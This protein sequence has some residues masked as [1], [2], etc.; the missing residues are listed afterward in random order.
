MNA[1]TSSITFPSQKRAD[2]EKSD[3]WAKECI[4][5]A[6]QMAMFNDEK[7]RQSQ[8]N[9]QIN[10]NL[11]NDILDEKD[12]HRICDPFNI[13]DFQAPAKVQNYPLCNPK[14][15]RLRGEELKRKF[16]WR[17]IVGNKEAISSKEMQKKEEIKQLLYSNLGEKYEENIAKQVLEKIERIRTTYQ[18]DREMTASKVLSYLWKTLD[19][20]TIFNDG[21]KDSL[22]AGEEI[23]CADIVA[24]EPIL[25]KV[26]PLNLYTIR[27]GE[28]AKIEDADIIIEDCYM[29][30]G[31]IIDAYY[32]YLK[33]ADV[34]RIE[35][36]DI[37]DTEAAGLL[38]Y[39]KDNFVLRNDMFGESGPMGM[40]DTNARGFDIF[41]SIY[42]SYGNIRVMRVVWKSRRKLQELTYIDDYGDEQKRVV[43]G[44][45]KANKT[46][47]EKTSE[48]W[49]NEFWE[50]TRIGGDL[51]IKIQPRPVQFR[52]MTNLSACQSGYIGSIY[53]TNL[54]RGKSLMD[55][56]KPYQYLY[57]TFMYRLEHAFAKYK[58]PIYELD[59]SKIPDEWTMDK[60]MY[61]AEVM[62]WAPID[63]FN[64]G[65]KGA[66]TGKLSG[67][68]NTTGK[69]LDA[70]IGN[71]IQQNINML[72]LIEV[73]M[74]KISGITPQREGDV[75]ASE[76]VGNVNQAITQSAFI[77]EPYF[78]LHDQTKL[79]VLNILLETAKYAWKESKKTVQFVLDDLSIQML[80]VDGE[81]F[82]EAEYDVHITNSGN[83]YEI[84]Q[85]IKQLA[86]AG[87]QNDKINFKQ[88]IDIYTSDSLSS[89]ARKIEAAEREKADG[90]Q[91]RF[92]QEMQV[93]QDQNKIAVENAER[94]MVLEEKKLELDK[95]KIDQDNATKI[96]IAEI[97]AYIGQES[98]DQ[99]GNGIPD[100][101]EIANLA[102][103]QQKANADQAAKQLDLNIKQAQLSQKMAIEKEKIEQIKT[104]NKSQEKINQE[105]LKRKDR[106]LDIKEKEL[107]IKKIAAKKKPTSSK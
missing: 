100:P 24:G 49:I 62:G 66:A 102:L 97:T 28:S 12:M 58:G 56:M 48:L 60:W 77:T 25:R 64:E 6:E 20:K 88:I 23:Y 83:V 44:S 30:P 2:S 27:S 67:S 54:G 17:V 78:Y 45:Y 4:E 72:N 104:Q 41:G 33:P 5:S 73:Q 75:S 26:N 65:K 92:E 107:V 7:V 101:M 63:P 22:L 81:Q 82:N 86:H 106:E 9:K 46:K 1:Y 47:G 68:F 59:L 76:L 11:Y 36:G 42:D 90:E 29:S 55:R 10:Y 21:F 8:Y 34:E 87:L 57:N 53:N 40:I 38:N 70:D 43:S 74:G 69:V 3:K 52:R 15:T 105:T 31:Q 35:S 13:G 103:S 89:M 37:N 79:R 80:E 99:N 32:D 98:L 94:M 95:Y 18:D 85:M 19:L 16:E 71:F 61:Y 39:K 50:G 91:Q 51:F 96:T 93:K 84:E 14:I